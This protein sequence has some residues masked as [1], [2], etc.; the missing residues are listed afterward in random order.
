MLQCENYPKR[1]Q[2]CSCLA[3]LSTRLRAKCSCE[4]PETQSSFS[5]PEWCQCG[6]FIMPDLSLSSVL[7]VFSR[8][9][10]AFIMCRCV[11]YTLHFTHPF[12][13]KNQCHRTYQPAMLSS[14]ASKQTALQTIQRL[15]QKQKSLRKMPCYKGIGKSRSFH[16]SFVS[17]K[18]THPDLVPLKRPAEVGCM[19][20]DL[21]CRNSRTIKPCQD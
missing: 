2:A 17:R 8:L 5:L 3:S 4:I 10:S 13:S 6:E 12:E 15:Q 19:L 14:R 1:S 16:G 21:A 18:E 9:Y 20:Q 11:F 7:S